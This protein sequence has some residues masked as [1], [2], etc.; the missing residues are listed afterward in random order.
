MACIGRATAGRQQA[1]IHPHT[2]TQ[3]SATGL[4]DDL[5]RERSDRGGEALPS[6][7]AVSHMTSRRSVR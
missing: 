1:L 2:S 4:I 7:C 5:R 6:W 3:Q